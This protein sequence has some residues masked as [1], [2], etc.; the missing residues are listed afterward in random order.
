MAAS[1]NKTFELSARLYRANMLVFAIAYVLVGVG[2]VVLVGGWL[3]GLEALVRLYPTFAAMVPSTAI[4]FIAAGGGLIAWS[5]RM[6][7]G[8]AAAAAASTII[9]VLALLNL[10][11]EVIGLGPGIDAVLLPELFGP[12]RMALS[13][14]ICFILAAIC[15]W[16]LARPGAADEYSF[17]ASATLGLSVAAVALVGYAFDAKALYQVFIFTAMALHTAVLFFFLF[18][19]LLLARP[20]DSWIGLLLRDLNSS[21]G[22]RRLCPWRYGARSCSASFVTRQQGKAF[23]QRT[24]V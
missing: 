3:L 19:A 18:L 9:G 1:A 23:S 15:L 6:D 4:S 22:A 10:G 11:V 7:G 12:D 21:S 8:C 5:R 20:S 14:S 24:F 13:T 16:Q 17:G 2:F